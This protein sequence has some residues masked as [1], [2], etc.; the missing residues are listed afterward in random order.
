MTLLKVF[1]ALLAFSVAHAQDKGGDDEY[2]IR[3]TKTGV[4]KIP[5][6]QTFRF[7]GSEIEGAAARPSQSL[8]GP[9]STRQEASL[10]P[11]RAHFRD[12]VLDSAVIPPRQGG[13]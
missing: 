2:I 1:G 3:R 6:K 4:V 11:M 9:R 13:N 10:V 5:K 7:E 12:E 8:L